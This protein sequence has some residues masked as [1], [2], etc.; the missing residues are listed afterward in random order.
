MLAG[1]LGSC[2]SL[3]AAQPGQRCVVGIG[4]R[5]NQVVGINLVCPLHKGAGLS[6]SSLIHDPDPLRH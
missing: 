3:A 6:F 5:L 1:T 2:R 4:A